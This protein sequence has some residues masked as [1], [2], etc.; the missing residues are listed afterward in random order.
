MSKP[1]S[2][3]GVRLNEKTKERL[4]KI[5][6]RKK[7]SLSKVIRE[8]LNTYLSWEKIIDFDAIN[9]LKKEWTGKKE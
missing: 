9:R 3:I 1:D 6:E 8:A 2:Y 5:A 7:I 4:L